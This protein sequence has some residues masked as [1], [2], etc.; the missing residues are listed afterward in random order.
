MEIP[1]WGDNEIYCFSLAMIKVILVLTR[2]TVH[3]LSFF[4]TEIYVILVCPR[5]M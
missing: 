2:I 5:E 3:I 4:S 1:K